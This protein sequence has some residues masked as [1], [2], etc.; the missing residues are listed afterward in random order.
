MGQQIK[1]TKTEENLRTALAGE[2][3]ARNRYNFYSEIAKSEGHEEIANF[4]EKTADNEKFHAKAWYK[5]LHNN[6][7][8]GTAECL[9]EAIKGE[10]FEHTDM[11]PSFVKTAE[12]E[13]FPIIA[14]LFAEIAKIEKTHEAQCQKLLDG[15]KKT[16]DTPDFEADM[17][18]VYCGFDFYEHDDLQVCPV[19]GQPSAFF[20]RKLN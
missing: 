12:E 6:N 19:C 11:Y 1:G 5:L 20:A 7:L 2:S 3:Q 14:S 8:P 15:I 9:E 10:N 16:E 13:G 4:F 17:T 18:C